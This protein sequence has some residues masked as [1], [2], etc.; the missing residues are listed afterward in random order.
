MDKQ[1]KTSIRLDPETAVMLV[2]LARDL[3]DNKSMA[4]RRAVRADYALRAALLASDQQEN[5]TR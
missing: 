2:E 5:E 4:I 3:E 1:L